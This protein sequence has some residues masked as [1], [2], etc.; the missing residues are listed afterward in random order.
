MPRPIL[1][2][3]VSRASV[4]STAEP[5]APALKAFGRC[6]TWIGAEVTDLE[7]ELLDPNRPDREVREREPP[8]ALLRVE[9]ERQPAYTGGGAL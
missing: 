3:P 4:P 7:L 9:R 6:A 8:H 5:R 1:N 2:G